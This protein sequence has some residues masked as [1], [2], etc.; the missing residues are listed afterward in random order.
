MLVFP[1]PPVGMQPS[2]VGM[3]LL[4]PADQDTEADA[5]LPIA[6]LAE[7]MEANHLGFHGILRVRGGCNDC[8]A[9]HPGRDHCGS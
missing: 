6:F 7:L 5:G 1:P 8:G 4:V 9:G 3:A 2:P